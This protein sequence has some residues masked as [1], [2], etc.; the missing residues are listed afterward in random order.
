MG[1][2]LIGQRFDRDR[3]RVAAARSTVPWIAPTAP[4]GR[5]TRTCWSVA[6]GSETDWDSIPLSEFKGPRVRLVANI[7]TND[8]DA[9]DKEGDDNGRR[10]KY[11]HSRRSAS[12]YPSFWFPVFWLA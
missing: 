6:C 8:D 12:M 3:F 5:Q 1:A 4:R 9:I 7:V 11:S 2:P 10:G